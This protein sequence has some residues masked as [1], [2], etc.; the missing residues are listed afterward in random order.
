MKKT[1]TLV[2]IFTTTGALAHTGIHPGPDAA[3]AMHR[4][5][6]EKLEKKKLKRNPGRKPAMKKTQRKPY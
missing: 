5:T 3:N 4:A 1:N 2:F 6:V